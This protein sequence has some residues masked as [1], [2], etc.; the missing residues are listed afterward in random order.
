MSLGLNE[1]NIPVYSG[2]SSRGVK[3][4]LPPIFMDTVLMRHT[5]G[6]NGHFMIHLASQWKTSLSLTYPLHD[7]IDSFTYSIAY[8]RDCCF[9]TAHIVIDIINY[10][11]FIQTQLKVTDRYKSTTTRTPVDR[12][13][14]LRSQYTTRLHFRNMNIIWNKAQ[15]HSDFQLNGQGSGEPKDNYHGHFKSSNY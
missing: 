12:S 3:L 8:H 9:F 6:M 2:L 4:Y 5:L 13:L 7:S 11:N 15:R 10:Q 14:E 1:L